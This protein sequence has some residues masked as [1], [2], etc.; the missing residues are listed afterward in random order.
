MSYSGTD[1][2]KETNKQ[3]LFKGNVIK[4]VSSVRYRFSSVD[5]GSVRN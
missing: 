1:A 5:F 4:A 3:L 2:C